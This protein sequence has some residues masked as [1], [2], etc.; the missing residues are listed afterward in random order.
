[1]VN[2][3]ILSII[4][5]III[6]VLIYFIVNRKKLKIKLLEEEASKGNPENLL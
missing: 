6:G 4:L 1:M 2:I 3:I 5:V